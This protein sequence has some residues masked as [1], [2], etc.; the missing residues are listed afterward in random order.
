MILVVDSSDP[1]HIVLRLIRENSQAE[2]NFSAQNLSETLL[3]EI[4]KFLKKQ[5]ISF[6]QLKK[7]EI[8]TDKGFSKTRTVVATVNALIFA[9]NLKQN[10][11][12]PVYNQ[13]PNITLSKK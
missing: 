10:L 2:H 1:E 3:S 7:I 5:K 13:A 11:F 4:K 9:L 12:K 6:S 8:K